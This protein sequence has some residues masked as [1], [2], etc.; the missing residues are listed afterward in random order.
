MERNPHLVLEGVAIA[1]YAIG[2]RWV[3]LHPR[4]VPPRVARARAAIAEARDG[5]LGGICS[6]RRDCDIHV[7]RGAGAYE[8][9]ESRRSSSPRGEARQPRLRRRFPAVVGST[10]PDGHQQRRNPRQRP[11]IVTRG[12]EW[13]VSLGPEKNTGPKLFCVSGQSRSR[14]LRSDDAHDAAE[15]IYDYPAASAAGAS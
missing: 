4:R 15:L 2:R 12:A 10:A 13:F 7:H 6:Q 8:A 14:C 11:Y 1:C 9:G 5:Y 3:H